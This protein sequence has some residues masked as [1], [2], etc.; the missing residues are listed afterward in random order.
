MGATMLLPGAGADLNALNDC[1]ESAESL[2]AAWPL[3]CL[4]ALG[5]QEQS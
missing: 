2:A 3:E 5:R 4:T 1:G